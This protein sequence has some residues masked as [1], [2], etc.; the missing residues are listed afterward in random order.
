MHHSMGSATYSSRCK[1]QQPANL[2]SKGCTEDTE[3]TTITDEIPAT[4]GYATAGVV[5]GESVSQLSG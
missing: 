2:V 5:S 3:E 4:A 1:G